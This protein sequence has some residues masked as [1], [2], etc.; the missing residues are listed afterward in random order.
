ME[1][2]PIPTQSVQ[3]KARR[4]RR[5]SA[6]ERDVSRVHHELGA[7]CSMRRI[8][9][10]LSRPGLQRSR[11]RGIRHCM[12][13]VVEEEEGMKLQSLLMLGLWA[14]AGSA[15]AQER[16]NSAQ[17][18]AVHNPNSPYYTGANQ[19][20]AAP[21]PTGYWEKTWGAIAGH[22]SQPILG[23]ALGASSK[24]EAGQLAIADCKA[25]GGG[26]LQARYH[27]LQPVCGACDW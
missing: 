4:L 13:A 22:S 23:A 12:A 21:Q 8:H 17:Y 26:G 5:I 19:Q 16:P 15:V 9:R 20:P 18:H 27:L 25:K 6:R 10:Q 7:R 24:D 14:F 2:L 11:R 1:L 3:Q